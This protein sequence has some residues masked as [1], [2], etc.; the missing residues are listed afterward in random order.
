M[1]QAALGHGA[2]NHVRGTLHQAALVRVFNAED[3]GAVVMPGDEP[4]VQGGAE[5]ANVHVARGGGGEAGAYLSFWNPVLHVLEETAV[6]SHKKPPGQA[7]SAPAYFLDIVIIHALGGKVKRNVRGDGSSRAFLKEECVGTLLSEAPGGCTG[8]PLQ[9]AIA[10]PGTP[11]RKRAHPRG[12]FANRTP[13]R[14]GSPA[15]SLCVQRPEIRVE[16]NRG[17]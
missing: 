13:R 10:K 2:V 3:K 11:V 9:D 7:G 5:I 14:G 12:P 17:R 1:G 16:M 4:G 6:G 8:L 15:S